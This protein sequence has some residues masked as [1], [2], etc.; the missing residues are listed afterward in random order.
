ME[1]KVTEN[2]YFQAIRVQLDL[3]KENLKVLTPP[4]NT[5]VEMI[6]KAIQTRNSQKKFE[7]YDQV[8]C[9]FDVEAKLTQP[10]RHGLMDAIRLAKSKKIHIA[11]S[12]PCFELW[13][14]LHHEDCTAWTASD[15][16]QRK[17]S[18]LNLVEDK[19]IQDVRGILSRHKQAKARA[20][21]LVQMHDQNGTNTLADR[22]PETTV[23]RL[24]DA[25][26][27]AFPLS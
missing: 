25:L 19:H 21:A 2:A 6:Q 16:V 18:Q 24:V 11:L 3:S 27:D 5:P 12:N 15:A 7:P 23:H 9:V 14:L 8:W 20:E 13:L 22:N 1:G 4:P 26:F 17:C 10:A